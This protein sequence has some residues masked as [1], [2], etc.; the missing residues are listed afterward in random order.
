ML[1]LLLILSMLPG[2]NGIH[3]HLDDVYEVVHIH[4]NHA[5]GKEKVSCIISGIDGSILNYTLTLYSQELVSP[6]Y[7][8]YTYND[9]EI[10]T[11]NNT[12]I[13]KCHY[14]AHS[15]GNKIAALS[16]CGGGFSGLIRG[17]SETGDLAIYPA[18]RY[19]EANS[20]EKH[21][22]RLR[23]A[24]AGECENDIVCSEISIH[25]IHVIYAIQQ[26][27]DYMFSRAIKDT[28]LHTIQR[29]LQSDSASGDS[30]IEQL[31]I[32]LLVINDF[33]R[34][35]KLGHQ[36]EIDTFNIVNI[37]DL[38]YDSIPNY[39]IHIV[40]TGQVTFA[41]LDPWVVPSP[42]GHLNQIDHVKILRNIYT[43]LPEHEFKV[44]FDV[45]QIF[46]GLDFLES[47]VSY[48]IL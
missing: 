47:A 45:I 10:L 12:D 4:T 46:S 28:A 21:M 44:S 9:K 36:V 3:A 14:Q 24:Q 8:S 17:D 19:L 32:E 1:L 29:S 11:A 5:I 25:S 15:N 41:H 43:W 31:Y 23:N 22:T 42:I 38:L 13:E 40:L 18:T 27:E 37:M 33:T 39:N 35:T 30:E 34:F 7:T 2:L 26:K 6:F 16:T 20:L 48:Y